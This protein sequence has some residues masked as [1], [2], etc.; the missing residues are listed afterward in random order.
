M[1]KIPNKMKVSLKMAREL[2]HYTQDEAAKLIGI[3]KDTLGNYERGGSL[4]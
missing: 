3:N 4:R 2:K 1:C